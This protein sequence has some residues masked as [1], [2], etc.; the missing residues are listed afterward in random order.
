M[1]TTEQEPLRY[2]DSD[3]HIL[4]PPTGMLDFAP[5]AYRD[6]IWHIETDCRRRRVDRLQ[7]LS[8]ARRGASPAPPASPTRWSTRVRNGEISY[9]ETRPSGWTAD[10]SPEGPRHGRDRALGPLPD[11]HAR[12]AE[13]EGRRSSA[14]YRP[15]PTTSGAPPTWP[16]ARDASS[17]PA[18]CH[19]CTIPRT[20][21]RWPR[22]SAHVAGLPGM[23]SVF[24]R[25]NP[26]VDWRHFNDPVYDPIWAAAAG[27][28]A[29]RSRSTP[30]SLPTCPG[31][32]RV[33]SWPGCATRTGRYVSLEEFEAAKDA[34]SGTFLPTSISPRR[35]PTP[36]T[37]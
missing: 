34:A 33:S 2:I 12:A 7:R 4:E 5:A 30:S 8:G 29:A 20:C 25:P 9:T 35:S 32:A 37:S 18:R 3:G 1:T 23:V 27:H 28:R 6:R 36:S 22:R 10:A 11:L 14:R 17:G 24:M 31:P 21:R 13:P 26:A 19:R 15:G 16:K